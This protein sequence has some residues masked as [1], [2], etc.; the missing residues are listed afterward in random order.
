VLGILVYFHVHSGACAPGSP[1]ADP[2]AT[3]SAAM[4]AAV[5]ARNNFIFQQTAFDRAIE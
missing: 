3:I 2:L 5:A 1:N 4:L